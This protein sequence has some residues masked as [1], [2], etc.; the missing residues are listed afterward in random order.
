MAKANPDP[1]RAVAAHR[2]NRTEYTNAVRDL[3]GV[4]IDG[5]SMLS[6]DN[7]GGFD[8]LADL[9]SVS[10]VLMESYMSAAR[11]VS[12]LAIGDPTIQVDSRQYTLDPKLLQNDHMSEDLP[13]GSGTVERNTRIDRQGIRIDGALRCDE[14]ASIGPHHCAG[15][16]V[17]AG[18]EL[19]LQV[20]PAVC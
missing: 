6:P 16:V 17:A 18:D 7:S 3:L 10:Q 2:L 4:E 11:E 5:A 19:Q 13:F 15:F 20:I 14:L 8:N 12:R 1:G 9:L